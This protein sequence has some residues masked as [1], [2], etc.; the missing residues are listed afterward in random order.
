[1][2]VTVEILPWL[3]TS[4]RPG[5]T[6]RILF[7]EAVPGRTLRDLLEEVAAKDDAFARLMYD[8]EARDL[9]YPVLA[10]VNDQLLEFRG[11]LDTELSEGDRVTFLAAYTGG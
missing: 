7:E 10:V 9:R 6:G 4:L 2:R 3:S 11:G 1:M 5:T 8:R